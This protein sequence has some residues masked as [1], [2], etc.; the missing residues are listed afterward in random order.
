MKKKKLDNNQR[1]KR[2]QWKKKHK[3]SLNEDR[4]R[5]TIKRLSRAAGALKGQSFPNQTQAIAALT[6]K[7]WE[8]DVLKPHY[9]TFKKYEHLWVHLIEKE[10][11]DDHL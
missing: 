2:H 1:Q 4:Q 6:E 5:D 11:N 8:I 3:K 9:A 10:S 7:C